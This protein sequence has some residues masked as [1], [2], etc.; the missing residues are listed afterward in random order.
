MEG[1]KFANLSLPTPTTNEIYN[2][3][4]EIPQ[5]DLHFWEGLLSSFGIIF[6]SEIVDK[7]FIL[8]IFFSTKIPKLELFFIASSSL[9]TMNIS[10]VVIGF[11]VPILFYR[12]LVEWV[13]LISFLFMGVFLFY[14]NSQKKNKTIDEKLKKYKKKHDLDFE[15]ESDCFSINSRNILNLSARTDLEEHLISREKVKSP[16]VE[17]GWM[18]LTTIVLAE[19]GDR[20]QIS[21]ILISASFN[22][23]GVLIGSCSAHLTCIIIAIFIG[24]WLGSYLDEKQMNYVGAMMFLLFGFQM[25]NNKFMIIWSR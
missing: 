16:H 13:A 14:D 15:Y 5:L 4:S 2:T 25:L 11:M 1:M 8:L 19:F 6:L 24:F 23:W 10:A 12:W 7:T 18:I 9:V 20:S 17:L 21:A 3:T 22:F